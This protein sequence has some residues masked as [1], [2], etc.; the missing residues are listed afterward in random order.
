MGLRTVLARNPLLGFMASHLAVGIGV[1]WSALAALLWLDVAGLRRLIAA[2]RSGWVAVA[3][4]MIFFA[5]T[6]GSAAMGGAVIGLHRRDKDDDDPPSGR[7]RRLPSLRPM[8]RTMVP[9]KA[10]ARR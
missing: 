1:G 5:I 4:L 7:R 6:F 10:P 2:D 8:T 9:A 3:M